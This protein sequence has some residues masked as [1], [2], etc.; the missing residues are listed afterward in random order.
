MSAYEKIIFSAIGVLLVFMIIFSFHEIKEPH[1]QEVSR[2]NKTIGQHFI[3]GPFATV[4][5][6]QS[7]GGPEDNCTALQPVTIAA[8]HDIKERL[9]AHSIATLLFDT[10]D[11]FEINQSTL[12]LLCNKNAQI[13]LSDKNG[14]ELVLQKMPF[15]RMVPKGGIATDE[16]TEVRIQATIIPIGAPTPTQPTTYGDILIPDRFLDQ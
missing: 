4:V 15:V 7:S 14:N 2:F 3:I 13:I 9:E 5:R 8:L 6:Q 1:G 11:I 12:L 16:G 10:G